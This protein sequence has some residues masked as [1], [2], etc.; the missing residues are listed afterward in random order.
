MM[1][2]TIDFHNVNR[3][4]LASAETL[5]SRLLPD[6]RREGV[7]W[8]ALNPRRADRNVG[9]FRINI[10]TGRWADF[11]IG[12]KGGDLVSLFA[13]VLGVRQGEAAARILEL[14]GDKE[15]LRYGTK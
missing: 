12:E 1:K 9:S 4:A 11:A 3:R 15:G 8:T 14:L 7:E 5:L 10:N 2:P 13:Y 6:G